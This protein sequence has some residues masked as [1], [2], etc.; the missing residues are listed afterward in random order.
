[1]LYLGVV[2]G[3]WVIIELLV[4]DALLQVRRPPPAC[5]L[6]PSTHSGLTEPPFL[7]VRSTLVAPSA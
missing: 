4:S 7:T 5:C 1:V 6:R 2:I 3:A